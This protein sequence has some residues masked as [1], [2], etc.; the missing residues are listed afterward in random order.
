MNS[1]NVASPIWCCTDKNGNAYVSLADNISAI[2]I[3]Y[4][5]DIV[6]RIYAPPLENLELYD[7]DLYPESGKTLVTIK[8]NK[9]ITTISNASTK[10]VTIKKYN[11]YFI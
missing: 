3:N 2:K 6:S 11:Q 4:E 10:I 9:K 7:S 5:T 8:G 1:N